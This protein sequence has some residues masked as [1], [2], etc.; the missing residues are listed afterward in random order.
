MR[1]SGRSVHAA[2]G[3]GPDHQR[4]RPGRSAGRLG[5]RF[6]PQC[7][8]GRH[9]Q[10]L[11][12]ELGPDGINVTVVHPGSTVTERTA[13][14]VSQLASAN[15]TTEEE[16]RARLASASSIG[17]MVT[18]DEVAAVVTFLAS[19]LSVAINGDAI[20]VGGGARGAIHY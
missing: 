16:A 17:R 12:D 7:R 8:R 6:G 19:P 2:A 4:Q 5:R 13:G 15:N 9:D 18:A 3:L 11:A 14:L 20:A 1:S 10:N